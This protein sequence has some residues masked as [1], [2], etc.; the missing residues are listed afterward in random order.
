MSQGHP[1]LKQQQLIRE[2]RR[3][4]IR[5]QQVLNA[6]LVVPRDEFVTKD[7]K[8]FSYRN[9]PLPIGL[10]QTIS[11]PLV[12]AK[13]VETLQ[14]K[15]ADRVLEVGTGSGYAAAILSQIVQEVFTVERYQSLADSASA[16]LKTLGYRNIRVR[17]GDGTLGW[18][19]AAPF[20]GIVVS[21]S[22]PRVPPALM[23]QLKEGGR[24]VIPVGMEEGTQQLLRLVRHGT[25]F[26]QEDLGPVRFVRLIGESGWQADE[27]SS[28]RPAR[29]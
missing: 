6:M 25:N 29:D 2:I 1:T 5:N 20:D 15:S 18:P 22:G 9:T 10:G 8:K 27:D 3:L 23:E 4:G 28:N 19:E 26:I 21:A 12:V 11:Q 17:C 24:L 7:L 13:M 14:L 16:R